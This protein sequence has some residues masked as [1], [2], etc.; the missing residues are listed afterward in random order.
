MEAWNEF[1]ARFKPEWD[2]EG[3]IHYASSTLMSMAFL[4]TVSRFISVAGF[5]SRG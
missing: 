2:C 5:A 4:P 3:E 1:L